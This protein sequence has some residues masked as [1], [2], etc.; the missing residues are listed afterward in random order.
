[1]KTSKMP[2]IG[3]LFQPVEGRGT[4]DA[5]YERML[6]I[7]QVQGTFDRLV[8]SGKREEAREFLDKYRNKIA[9]ASLSS[10]VQSDL[11]EFSKL[12]RQI[13]DSNKTTAEKD[14]MLKRIDDI[15]YKIARQ[16]L[17]ITGETRPQ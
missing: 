15:Q 1:M 17:T 10:E 7:Q 16:F 4:L 12:R 11:G 3:G 8:D 9:L 14:V 6:E 13:I 2:F 5:A